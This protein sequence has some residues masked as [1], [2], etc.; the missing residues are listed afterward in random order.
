MDTCP[1]CKTTELGGSLNPTFIM[2]NGELWYLGMLAIP[3]RNWLCCEQC[4]VVVC[5][6]CCA[7]P[8]SGYCNDCFAAEYEAVWQEQP[9][10]ESKVHQRRRR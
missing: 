7:Y 8:Q 6:Q 2:A 10:A 5:H 1:A 4:G 3:P 9:N